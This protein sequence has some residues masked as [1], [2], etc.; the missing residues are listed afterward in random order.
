[1]VIRARAV[2]D[3]H[4]GLVGSKLLRP[5]GLTAGEV[6]LA[7]EVLD[8][9]VI[10]DEGEVVATLEVVAEHLDSMDSSEELLLMDGVVPLS[11]GELAGL[12]AD[13]LQPM[14]LI[15]EEDRAYTDA[16]GISIELK[17]G[18]GPGEGDQEDGGREE[19]RFELMECRDGGRGKAG[20]KGDRRP[21]EGGQRSGDGGVTLDEPPVENSESE[22]GAEGGEVGGEGVGG[23][24]GDLARISANALIRDNK[25]KE[26]CMALTKCALREFHLE[27]GGIESVKDL[28]DVAY[29]ICLSL[30]EDD[31]VV[32][33]CQD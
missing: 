14:P 9:V 29:M 30:G 1:M 5:T 7:E 24:G 21:G 25:A 22:E 17:G 33:V 2:N 15:L 8:G 10:G 4:V 31:D 6:A 13:R 12:I 26:L 16:G 11:S 27:V 23:D 18:G 20:G 32:E 28:L 19:G 3:G